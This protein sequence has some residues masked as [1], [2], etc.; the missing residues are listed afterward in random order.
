MCGI[1][2]IISS[3]TSVSQSLIHK[4]NDQM[5]FR[6]PDDEGIFTWQGFGIGMR[7]LSIVGLDNGR[8]PLSNETEDLHLVFNGEIYNHLEL[9]KELISRGHRFRSDSDGEVILHLFEEQGPSCVERLNGMFAFA[10]INTKNQSAWIVRD[11]VGIKPLYYA[12]KEDNLVFSSNLKSL[13]QTARMDE[14]D[15]EALLL[16]SVL[17]YVPAPH[18]IFKGIK[19]LLPGHQIVYS[20]GK[21]EVSQYWK[22]PST[23]ATTTHEEAVGQVKQLLEDSVRLQMRSDVPVASFL[24]GGLD[25]S[26]ISALFSKQSSRAI[27]TYT[28][29][30]KGKKSPDRALAQLMSEKIKSNHHEFLIDADSSLQMIS[31]TLQFFDEPFADSAIIPT[32]KLAKHCRENRIKVILTGAGGDEIFGGY[33]RHSIRFKDRLSHRFQNLPFHKN[34]IDL[35]DDPSRTRVYSAKFPQLGYLLSTSGIRLAPLEQMLGKS[36]YRRA[37]ELLENYSESFDGKIKEFGQRKGRLAFDFEN[38]LVDNVLAI[39][40]KATMANSIEARVPLLD[41]RLVEFLFQLPENILFKNS[42]VPPLLTKPLLAECAK[43]DLPDSIL[44]RTKSGFNGP[45][46]TWM[47][48]WQSNSREILKPD[49]HAWDYFDFNSVEKYLKNSARVAENKLVSENLFNVICFEKWLSHV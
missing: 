3:Q 32:F 26:I 2:G 17:S 43:D 18:T 49:S 1:S 22:I 36:K 24:S 9:R 33:P 5:I 30:F 11:R 31:E 39:T 27:E 47:T 4:M 6:G 37:L 40:D 7:R 19:K 14:I 15:E 13:R 25:S 44:N 23:V 38:Y 42:T 41:H 10:L 45:V 16:Y 35:F 46:E 20:A 48:E 34:L 12:I 29:D 28:I 8:Q 21:F